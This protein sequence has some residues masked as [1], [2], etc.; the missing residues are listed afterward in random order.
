LTVNN[1]IFTFESF[2]DIRDMLR[3]QWAGLIHLALTQD[4]SVSTEEV[5]K[6]AGKLDRIESQLK[7]LAN[8]KSM[9]GDTGKVTFDITKLAG[10]VNLE[11]LQDVQVRI[12]DLLNDI[13]YLFAGRPRVRF[14]ERVKSTEV[15]DWLK[16][17]GPFLTRFKW[18]TD[19]PAEEL[20]Q[21]WSLVYWKDRRDI[22][23]RTVF[24]LNSIANSLSDDDQLSLAHSIAQKLNELY[25]PPKPAPSPPADDDIPF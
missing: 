1:A 6:L 18:S 4:Q 12:R 21:R 9:E 13:C 23:F 8:T 25:E 20:L 5:R 3:K 14:K 7:L 19:V 22:P 2:E 24:D 16:E 17:L 10:D 11:S 15:V